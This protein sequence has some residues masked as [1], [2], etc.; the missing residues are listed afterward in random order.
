MARDAKVSVIR[1]DDDGWTGAGLAF[2]IHKSIV[3]QGSDIRR[4]TKKVLI[5]NNFYHIH[6]VYFSQSARGITPLYSPQ[7]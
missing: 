7:G 4:G 1:R 5:S 2:R 3:S 6:P